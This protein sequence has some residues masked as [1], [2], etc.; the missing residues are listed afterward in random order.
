MKRSLIILPLL[1]VLSACSSTLANPNDPFS[2]GAPFQTLT[3]AFTPSLPNPEILITETPT[4]KSVQAETV[5]L[6]TDDGINLSGTLFKSGDVA[7]I[8][9]YQGTYRA[10]QENWHPLA[11]LLVKRG[12]TVLTFDFRGWGQSTEGNKYAALEVDMRGAAKFLTSLGY[13][14]IICGGAS[15]GGTACIHAAL[16]NDLVGVF[17]LGSTIMAG[18]GELIIRAEDFEHLTM[19]KL[20]ITSE[21]DISLVVNDTKRMYELSPEPKEILILP[22]W[23][24]GTDLFDSDAGGDLTQAILIFIEGLESNK[25]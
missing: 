21:G 25:K 3:A 9:A 16:E 2:E 8:L 19:P 5:T 20:F 14:Q 15:M 17:T 11:T 6:P 22:G 4:P 1:V 18:Y 13:D 12:F 23:Q 10:N 24:H 7:V